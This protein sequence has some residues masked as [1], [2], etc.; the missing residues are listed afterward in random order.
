MGTSALATPAAPPPPA[1][2]W[3]PGAAVKLGVLDKIDGTLSEVTIATGAAAT[4][5]DLQ[6]AV[7]SCVIRPPDEIPD[8]AVFLT[9]Q[10]PQDPTAPPLYRGW[11]V[12]SIPGATVVGDAS[13]TFRIISCS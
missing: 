4:I 10:N 8:A 12:R 11:M 3:L 9:A 13:E 6:I 5:G 2:S 7:Q 1:N